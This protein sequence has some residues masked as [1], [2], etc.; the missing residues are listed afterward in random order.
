M[1]SVLH[2]SHTSDS[3]LMVLLHKYIAILPGGHCDSTPSTFHRPPM[4]RL[5]ISSYSLSV[6]K[7]T[8]CLLKS[9]SSNITLVRL[10]EEEDAAVREDA[11]DAPI[12]EDAV[13]EDTD[14]I[15]REDDGLVAIETKQKTFAM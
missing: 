15:D 13:Q 8:G 6:I 11:A 4:R 12:R 9:I 10:F 14:D 7:V 1:T 2:A 5:P 3:V